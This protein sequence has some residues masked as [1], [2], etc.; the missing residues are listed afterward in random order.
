MNKYIILSH[1]RSGSSVLNESIAPGHNCKIAFEIL[2]ES[3]L[4][5]NTNFDVKPV[6]KK[7]YGFEN[8]PVQKQRFHPSYDALY[9]KDLSDL[10]GNQISDLVD[11][12]SYFFYCKDN[13]EGFKIMSQQLSFD[14]VLWSDLETCKVVHV[15]RK[16]YLA[17]LASLLLAKK[18]NV[19][20][21]IKH[22]EKVTINPRL[23]LAYFTHM[24]FLLDFISSNYPS[25]LDIEFDELKNWDSVVRKFQD[26]VG[27][28]QSNLILKP[29]YEGNSIDSIQRINNL[30]ELKKFFSD[31]RYEIFFKQVL[32]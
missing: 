22:N 27:L 16:N 7:L 15:Y 18:T 28:R 2:H 3:L 4:F 24:D 23:A 10:F 30:D 14:S 20:Q 8:W 9:G 5:D 29:K 21:N 11:L 31:S 19:W 17:Q 25:R 13:F 6:I 26:F 32:R 12:R 1:Y